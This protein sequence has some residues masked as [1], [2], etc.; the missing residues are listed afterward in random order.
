[1]GRKYIGTGKYLLLCIAGIVIGVASGCSTLRDFESRHNA[2]V[3]LE[4]SRKLIEQGMFDNA[5]EE[6]RRSL[7]LYSRGTP[8][9]R[10]L[11]TLGTIHAHFAYQGK[12]YAKSRDYFDELIHSF[13]ESDLVS[14]AELWVRLLEE[15]QQV[16]AS[17]KA[18]EET[19]GTLRKEIEA[20]QHLLTGQRLQ[21]SGDF[22]EATK[23]NVTALE[24]E[25]GMPVADEALY[26]LGLLYAHHDNPEKD[27]I[28]SASYFRQ[29]L[30]EY[31]DSKLSAHA[32]VWIGVLN[33]IE[34]SKQVDIE[35]EK[36]KKELER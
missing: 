27:F 4:Q 24:R 26:N 12:D 28:K 19:I 36:R 33:V 14:E 2:G 31:P 34:K 35:I 17:R 15:L 20:L 29:L 11:F 8:A 7:E 16:E 32:A 22:Q 13:P 1:L 18:G 3:A 30:R 10:A 5:A 25:K 21:F 9:D 23:E 6:S